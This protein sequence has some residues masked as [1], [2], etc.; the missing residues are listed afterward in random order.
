MSL[1]AEYIW[2]DAKGN[3]RSK[4]RMVESSPSL[5][6]KDIPTWN[7]DGSSTGQAVGHDSEVILKPCKIVT[8]PFRGAPNVLILC[9]TWLVNDE[10]HKN[11]T[12]VPALKIF[13]QAPELA[14]RFG[15][16]QEFFLSNPVTR[17]PVAFLPRTTPESES[18]SES[19]NLNLVDTGPALRA[20]Q[21]EQRSCGPA[22]RASQSE[23]RSCGPRPQGDYYCGVGGG[24]AIARPCVEEAFKNCLIAGLNLTGMNAEVA[25][26]QWEFQV[27]A[28]GIDVCDQLYLMRYI[29]NR[30]AENYGYYLEIHPKPL[31][32]D[33]NGSGCHCNFSTEP[34]RQPGGY[35]EIM[36]AIAK[37]A[38]KHK[39]H[40]AVYGIDNHMRLTGLHETS[41][42]E[43]FSYG[44]ANRGA[45]VRIP[46]VVKSQGCGYLEDRRPAANMDPY[47]VTS[48]IFQTVLEAMPDESL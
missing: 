36:K 6:I 42:M 29:I 11:N 30:T 17:L 14:P 39:E 46:N 40:I 38:A 1:I 3:L 35:Q 18:E 28:Y 12:R 37:L 32:G 34:M 4:T 10:P 43:R 33:W 24:N 5:E 23:Q 41:S 15:I 44:V 45:S 13:N 2:T 22:L 7:Y 25:P 26:S 19:E 9:D 20:S 48:I 31:K 47:Q 21:S 16:E 8:D 27:D